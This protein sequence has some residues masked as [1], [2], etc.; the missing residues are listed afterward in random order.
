MPG[1]R[2]CVLPTNRASA[3]EVR[4]DGC[5]NMLSWVPHHDPT[6]GPGARS[7][8][9]GRRLESSLPTVHQP[10]SSTLLGLTPPGEPWS[11]TQKHRPQPQRVSA[12][13]TD[14]CFIQPT[15][16]LHTSKSPRV[17]ADGHSHGTSEY[18]AC[19]PLCSARGSGARKAGWYGSATGVI[20]S[21][22]RGG[23]KVGASRGRSACPAPGH[24][25]SSSA[26]GKTLK[27][28]PGP[29][30]DEAWPPEWLRAAGTIQSRAAQ[31][32]SIRSSPPG[33]AAGIAQHSC[34]HGHRR[35][36]WS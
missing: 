25:Q 12:Q 9:A 4:T 23:A 10:E 2:G 35:A 7:L 32:G 21:W 20:L 3:G 28:G 22:G 27:M 19:R 33:S 34:A 24:A 18:P 31:T 14:L 29:C 1:Q 16:P 17:Q 11:Q 36:S 5:E 13:V 6:T 26:E 8:E 15:P 30:K